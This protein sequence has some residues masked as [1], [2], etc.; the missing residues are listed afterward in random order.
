MF[1][2]NQVSTMNWFLFPVFEHVNVLIGKIESYL[3]ATIFAYK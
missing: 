1:N 3:F 2:K